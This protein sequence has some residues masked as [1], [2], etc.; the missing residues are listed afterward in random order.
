MEQEPGLS[1]EHLKLALVQVDRMDRF[2]EIKELSRFRL[3]IFDFADEESSL[4]GDC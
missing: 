1:L 2:Q 3:P 4:G